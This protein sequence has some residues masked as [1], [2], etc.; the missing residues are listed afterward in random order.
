MIVVLLGGLWHGAAWHFI[1]WG[2]MHGVL[3]VIYSLF[4]APSDSQGRWQRVAAVLVFFHLGSVARV[5]FRAESFGAA[6]DFMADAFVGTTAGLNLGRSVYLFLL[7]GL[8]L[9]NWAEPRLER[10]AD[11]FDNQR[12]WL[13]ALL[14]VVVLTACAFISY[15]LGAD[16]AFYY[17]QF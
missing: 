3:F 6:I 5:F 2:A 11:A 1:V 10:W 9:H 8:L 17:F 7:G 14:A 12:S 13:L 15:H 16:R 4:P